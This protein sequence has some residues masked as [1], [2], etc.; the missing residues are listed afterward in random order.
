[1]IV[2]GLHQ[3]YAFKGY[4][5]RKAAFSTEA[6]QIFL[7][8][9]KRFSLKCPQCQSKWIRKHR[10]TTQTAL[11][12]PASSAKLVEIHYN[13]TQVFCIRCKQYQTIRPPGIDPNAQATR[14][15]MTF[16][17]RLTRRL[18]IEH[19][20]EFVPVS[21]ATI[22]RWDTAILEQTL[23]EPDLDNVDYLLIDEK[24]VRKSGS[25]PK[26]VTLVLNAQTGELLSMTEGRKKESLQA[27]TDLLTESQ[28]SGIK[29]VCID[30]SGA[31]YQ[32]I[33][34][35][36]PEAEVVFDKFHIVQNFNKVIDEVR[37]DE[38]SKADKAGKKFIK[39]QRFNLFRRAENRT[40]RQS[41]TLE[42]LL[43]VNEPLSKVH[44]L[45]EQLPVFWSYKYRAWAERYLVDWCQWA[46]ESGLEPVMR[47][48]R[49]LW[50]SRSGLLAYFH[51][52][53]TNGLMESFNATAQRVM[54]RCCGIRNLRYLW[55]KLR[56]ESLHCHQQR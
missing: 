14:R 52:R 44:L 51:H 40:E 17:S 53:I 28:A 3:L 37:R 10:N 21:S 7:V 27:F 45:G 35:D 15:L 31:Y 33:R 38:A 29:A 47:F 56:Q 41:A 9:D 20:T 11:D 46:E 2:S 4:R 43:A 54:Q 12:L 55:L 32:V 24:C 6:T 36:L 26:Y 22:Y 39:G 50:K 18:P 16:A 49:G 8:P 48:A 23:P 5:I 1:M 19:V 13:A 30:R 34:E 25:G 42:Q